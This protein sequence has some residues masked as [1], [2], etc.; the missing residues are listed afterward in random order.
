M[1][2]MQAQADSLDQEIE[3]EWTD[4]SSACSESAGKEAEDGEG[5]AGSATSQTE[6]GTLAEQAPA[7]TQEGRR[8]EGDGS[9]ESSGENPASGGEELPEDL[10]KCSVSRSDAEEEDH[11]TDNGADAVRT[12][13]EDKRSDRRAAEASAHTAM[14]ACYPIAQVA[15]AA[16]PDLATSTCGY[17]W[18]GMDDG[19]H[20]EESVAAE[21]CSKDTNSVA[22]ENTGDDSFS[23]VELDVDI[24]LSQEKPPDIFPCECKKDPEPGKE[25]PELR[26]SVSSEEQALVPTPLASSVSSCAPELSS[27]A[28]D[29][30]YT[31][32]C[33]TT[34]FQGSLPSFDLTD[35]AHRTLAWR[36]CRGVVAAIA[37]WLLCR[38]ALRLS[39][40]HAALLAARKTIRA[41]ERSLRSLRAEVLRGRA[42]RARAERELVAVRDNYLALRDYLVASMFSGFRR[43]VF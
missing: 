10:A 8:A 3:G 22:L 27:L 12:E 15:D 19:K 38:L 23:V 41:Q 11:D 5:V 28:F 20:P 33:I 4:I 21:E 6:D 16:Q 31:S 17:P 43:I 42:M 9:S 32:W 40:L 14:A 13:D 36:V 39:K 7:D 29:P 37:L 18:D 30:E 26:Q 1:D 24:A 25:N 34:P 35:P 2:T